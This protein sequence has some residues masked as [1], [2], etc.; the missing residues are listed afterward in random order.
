MLTIYTHEDRKE[1]LNELKKA[2]ERLCKHLE[3]TGLFPEKLDTYKSLKLE[4]ETILHT[5]FSQSELSEQSRAIPDL[6]KLKQ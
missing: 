2:L 1:H 3:K 6:Y 4:A 5:N